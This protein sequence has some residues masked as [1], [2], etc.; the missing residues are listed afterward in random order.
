MMILTQRTET[1]HDKPS[2][3]P[4]IQRASLDCYPDEELLDSNDNNVDPAN[5][6]ITRYERDSTTLDDLMM[7]LDEESHNG[8]QVSPKKCLS[9]IIT[10]L[11]T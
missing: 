1:Q 8:E 5:M 6:M 11:L 3:V 7:I 10:R 4:S 2:K 9:K